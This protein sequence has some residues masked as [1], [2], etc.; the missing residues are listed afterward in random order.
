ME[1]K[2]EKWE[3]KGKEIEQC[4]IGE[5]GSQCSTSNVQLTKDNKSAVCMRVEL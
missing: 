1:E 3:E 5:G 2:D 4:M